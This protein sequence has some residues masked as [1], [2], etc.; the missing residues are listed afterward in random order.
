MNAWRSDDWRRRHACVSYLRQPITCCAERF[1]STA[2][3]EWKKRRTGRLIK[4]LNFSCLFVCSWSTFNLIWKL[5]KSL[6]DFLLFVA[7]F[8]LLLLLSV[9]F[10]LV[11]SLPSH[12]AIVLLSSWMWRA[13]DYF[14]LSLFLLSVQLIDNDV[15][16]TTQYSLQWKIMNNEWRVDFQTLHKPES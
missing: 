14:F 9:F 8:S 15:L 12:L 5:L 16:C 3:K 13:A 2:T 4:N 1:D 6:V 7:V 10:L 11:S